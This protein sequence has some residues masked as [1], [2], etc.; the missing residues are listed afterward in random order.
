VEREIRI[1][2]GAETEAFA[3]FWNEQLE[4]GAIPPELRVQVVA[5]EVNPEGLE[6]AIP[7]EL[8]L[9]VA[10]GAAGVV[11]AGLAKLLWMQIKQYF[12]KKPTR[13]IV[14][15]V[16]DDRIVIRDADIAEEAAPKHL[17]NAV[18]SIT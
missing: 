18:K 1:Q 15:L 7:A 3:S 8:L 4:R 6:S 2:C 16:G 14:V 11:G 12:Q 10:K 13:E 5:P 9:A 17:E